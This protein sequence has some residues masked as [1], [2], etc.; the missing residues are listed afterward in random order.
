MPQ[1][2]AADIA[3]DIGRSEIPTGGF[4]NVTIEWIHAESAVI[5]LGDG[6][7][8]VR[9]V[10][11]A[12]FSQ[13]DLLARFDQ[14][15]HEWMDHGVW[16]VGSGFGMISARQAGG[17]PRGLDEGMLKPA[18]CAQERALAL[19]R[20]AYRRKS[21]SHRSIRA[22]WN[23]PDSS[24]AS[25]FRGIDIQGRNP[26]PAHRHAEVRGRECQSPRDCT[27]RGQARVVVADECELGL[28]WRGDASGERGAASKAG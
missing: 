14:R 24:V 23:K 8:A 10:E 5:R 25:Q 6:E 9:A 27:M 13:V 17:V 4:K 28:G 21:P 12:V 22:C 15:T 1:L 19:A 7:C 18:T 16:R 26:I 2:T 3:S 11:P 20:E